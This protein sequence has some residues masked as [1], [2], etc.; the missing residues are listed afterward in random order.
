MSRPHGYTLIELMVVVA[1]VAILAA[2]ALP[3]YQDS[4]R[5]TRRSDARVAL[6]ETAQSL[7]RC[8]TQF[9]RYDDPACPV[10]ASFASAGGHYTI[11]VTVEASDY[12]LR[13]D[14]GGAQLSDTSCAALVLDGL[15]VRTALDG[16]GEAATACW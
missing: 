3:A 9:G 12:S 14:A 2:V 5:K 10:A 15:G 11:T 16:A 7:E 1:I 4:V 13:A 8:R 6:V